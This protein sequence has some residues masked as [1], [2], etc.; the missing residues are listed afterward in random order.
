MK[1]PPTKN[2]GGGDGTG[3]RIPIRTIPLDSD[4]QYLV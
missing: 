2:S 3:M 4:V 1:G